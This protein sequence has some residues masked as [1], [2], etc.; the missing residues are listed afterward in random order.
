MDTK[1]NKLKEIIRKND[2]KVLENYLS[3]NNLSL[4]DMNNGAF[5]ALIYSI[6][7]NSSID[8]IKYIMS[9]CQYKSYNF[10]ITE[11]NNNKIPLFSAIAQNNFKVADL[12]LANKA[13]INCTLNNYNII[14]NLCKLN[15][16]NDKN[17]RYILSHGF[18]IKFRIS[19]L[20]YELI[21]L[22][23]NKFLNIIFRYLIFDQV[24]ILG[25]LE[26]YKNKEPLTD[27][28]LV[29]VLSKEKN[30]IC[31]NETMYKK[32]SDKENVEAMR[33][34]FEHDGS[35]KDIIFCRINKYELLEKAVKSNSFTFVKNILNYSTFSFKNIL[36]ESI[37]LEANKNGNMDIMK[38][39]ITTSLK[40]L[41][42]KIK[43]E[44]EIKPDI[45]SNSNYENNRKSEKEKEKEENNDDNVTK[46]I[47]P[48]V[49][50]SMSS[51]YD[52]SYLNVILNKAIKIKNLKLVEYM[53]EDKE[54]K[55]FIN[56]NESDINGE[57]PIIIAIYYGNVEI[58]EYLLDHGANCNTKDSNGNP[59]LSLA[60]NNNP[61]LV[62]YLLRKPNININE[63]DANGNYPL[64]NAINQNDIDNVILLVKYSNDYN[65][66]M[67]INDMNGNTPITLSYKQEHFEIFQFLIKYL[68]IINK[69]DAS[70]N[71]ILYYSINEG[72]VTTTKYLISNG[73]DVNFKDKFGNSALHMSIYKKNREMISTLLQNKNI[74]L[75]TVNRRGES[76]L[77]T[78]IKIN[79]YSCK[80]NEDIIKEL[81]KRGSNVNFIDKTGNSPLVYA[82]QKRCLPIVKLLIKKGANVNFLIKRKNQ[83]LLMY[84]LELEDIDIVKH[85]VKSGADINFVNGKGVSI[86]RKASEIGNKDIFEFLIKYN[87]NNCITGDVYENEI[88]YT[89][90][91]KNRLDLL[92]ILV[93]NNLD[94]NIPDEDGDTAIT[95]AVKNRTIDI[96]KYLISCGA[97]IHNINNNGQGIDDINYYCNYDHYWNYY[98]KISN[99]IKIN[100]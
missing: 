16:L 78:I 44:I 59:L 98:N 40:S 46:K 49:T 27:R 8:V 35:D 32:A 39:L 42:K 48:S 9:K 50:T 26:F 58:F 62:R 36:T 75:N 25:L 53:V 77:I 55:S 66:A 91:S 51:S 90:I 7:Q 3:D 56:I 6:E 45:G 30:K 79:D 73:I 15:L 72:D 13:N 83:S 34:L 89:V 84:A 20:I 52:P 54:F 67:D 65:I 64:I 63:P 38:L 33:V 69:E 92:K 43:K 87:S 19:G 24:F 85:L 22:K 100:K 41:P 57:Y 37:L 14:Y 82:I 5:D 71:S 93:N 86:L 17:L 74:I 1:R 28:Q 96:L 88:V 18:N 97:D 60:I 99:I 81:I 94:I 12:L 76:P 29:S 47:A 4:K 95:Y 2:I 31:V 10:Y 21:E 11:N 61:L 23:K 70:G 80:D 68:D